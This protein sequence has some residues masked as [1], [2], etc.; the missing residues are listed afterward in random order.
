MAYIFSMSAFMHHFSIPICFDYDSRFNFAVGA[1]RGLLKS[2]VAPF[3]PSTFVFNDGMKAFG[4]MAVKDECVGNNS[5]D[6]VRKRSDGRE[7]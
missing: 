3:G 7:K 4:A 6:W 5:G 1:L 2:V